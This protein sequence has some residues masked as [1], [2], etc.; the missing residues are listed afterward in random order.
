[1]KK[2]FERKTVYIY[3]LNGQEKIKVTSAEEAA[4]WDEVFELAEEVDQLLLDKP[5]SI[6]LNEEQRTEMSLYLAQQRD[7]LGILFGGTGDGESKKESSKESADESK[8]AKPKLVKT[9]ETEGVGK[10][11]KVKKQ[12]FV[13]EFKR[14]VEPLKDGFSI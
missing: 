5:P 13:K 11:E 1:M 3:E 14:P 2:R 10:A 4:H 12:D 7:E 9:G 6:K 8:E